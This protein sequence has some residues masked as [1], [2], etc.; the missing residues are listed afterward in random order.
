MKP[1]HARCVFPLLLALCA[2]PSAWAGLDEGLAAY[3]RGD[4]ATAFAELETLGKAGNAKAQLL[5]GD[6]F[7]T[8]KGIPRDPDSAE[9]WYNKAFNNPAADPE[10]KAKAS[11]GLTK[12]GLTPTPTPTPTLPS[13]TPAPKPTTAPAVPTNP[14]TSKP[15]P[16][17]VPPPTAP[18]SAPIP[19]SAVAPV[20]TAAPA[21]A[22]S[23]PAPKPTDTPPDTT[24]PVIS[25]S[26][27]TCVPLTHADFAVQGRVHDDRGTAKVR[28]NDEPLQ[29]SK[30]G[31]F[32]LRG[33][34]P[35]GETVLKFVAT[36]LN[37][38]ASTATVTLVRQA[39]EAAV[40]DA[41]TEWA[42]QSDDASGKGQI[43]YTSTPPA[44]GQARQIEAEGRACADKLLLLADK[45]GKLA[46]KQM[47]GTA[48]LNALADALLKVGGKARETRIKATP[49]ENGHLRATLHDI[50]RI[51]VSAEVK[52]LAEPERT[53]TTD[54]KLGRCLTLR[55][56]FEVVP[57]SAPS[58]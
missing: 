57:S 10:T 56:R 3:S 30:D 1:S 38:N 34:L 48:R 45:S 15:A 24:P 19:T 11:A 50:T 16:T 17:P 33:A 29:L 8:G 12:M 55:L 5:L 41:N 13:V 40:A 25:F 20:P 43:A 47:E 58:P 27:S 54:P 18:T 37:N 44:L 21:A 7:R 35:L 6:L 46:D 23:A 22:P 26:H 31:A 14:A 39:E 52:E 51:R 53:W 4:F 36:D 49:L 42:Q 28:V 9:L 32:R 2:A